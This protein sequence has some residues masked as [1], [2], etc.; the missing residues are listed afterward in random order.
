[1]VSSALMV[2]L[3]SLGVT[4]ITVA[5]FACRGEPAPEA[6][7]GSASPAAAPGPARAP[8]LGPTAPPSNAARAATDEPTPVAP[9]SAA[10]PSAAV[11]P[12]TV[13]LVPLVHEELLGSEA[14][15]MAQMAS[16]IEADRRTVDAREA[17]PDEAAAARAYFAG[18]PP[19]TLPEAWQT[20]E[21]V[22]VLRFAPPEVLRNGR[23][24]ANG[25]AGTVVLQPPSTEPVFVARVDE[26]AGARFDGRE[27]GTWTLDLLAALPTTE[28]P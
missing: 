12:R 28:A 7:P 26:V 2:L 11:V 15:G 3:R 5:L 18:Q 14:R 22:V 10:A 9:P 13:R 25:V 8:S 19:A 4:V 6:P 16:T 1:M 17:A 21:V 23:R 24:V 27:M 20:S